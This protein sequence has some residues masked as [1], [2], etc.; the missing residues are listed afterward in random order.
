MK[1]NI[2]NK[3]VLV[4]SSHPFSLSKKDLDDLCYYASLNTSKKSRICSHQNTSDQLHEMFIFHQKNYYV[5][6]HKHYNKAESILILKGNADLILFNDN[7]DVDDVIALDELSSGNTFY[8]RID[9]PI[10]HSLVIKSEN[11]I[12]Y[13]ATSGPL[14]MENTEFAKWSPQIKSKNVNNFMYNLD[15]KINEFNKRQTK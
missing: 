3:E 15:I 13:E 11:L 10:F 7:G 5:R 2:S 1:L 6:P 9:L 4:S 12:F 8:H 14:K